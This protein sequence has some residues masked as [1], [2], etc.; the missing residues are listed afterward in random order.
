[1][2]LVRLLRKVSLRDERLL[3]NQ[4]VLSLINDFVIIHFEKTKVKSAFK[5]IREN[6]KEDL[7]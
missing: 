5:K 2:V 1:M 3:Q 7:E 6:K 4:M